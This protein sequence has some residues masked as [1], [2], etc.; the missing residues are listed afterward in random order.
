M[1]GHGSAPDFLSRHLRNWLAPRIAP[2]VAALRAL[3]EL[4]GWS[5]L[6]VVPMVEAALWWL[7]GPDAQELTQQ[8]LAVR[9][10]RGH[11]APTEDLGVRTIAVAM[12]AARWLDGAES[13]SSPAGTH[14]SRREATRAPPCPRVTRRSTGTASSAAPDGDSTSRCRSSPCGSGR[15]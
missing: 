8:R 5:A 7:E 14:S 12:A 13:T 4:I 3:V 2:L 10:L 6:I 9:A 11:R 1:D 15:W